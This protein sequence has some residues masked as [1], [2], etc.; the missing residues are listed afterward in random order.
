MRNGLYIVDFHTHIVSQADFESYFAEDCQHHFIKQHGPF[1][2]R[3]LRLSDPHFSD[4]MRHVSFN[5]R[6]EL[7]RSVYNFCG[8]LGLVEAIRIFKTHDFN[9]LLKS[10]DAQGI[11]HAI[12]SS[13]EPLTVTENLIKLVA[14]HKDRFSIFASVHRNQ[15]DPAGYFQQLLESGAVRGLKLHPLV[16]GYNCGELLDKTR[17]VLKVASAHNLP[18]FI[19]TGHIPTGALAGLNGCNDA[20][21]VEPLLAEFP[22]I[23]FVLAHIGWESWRTMLKL[24]RKYPKVYVETSWQPSTIIRRAVDT[25]GSH[26]VIFGSDFPLFKQG[27]ALKQVEQALT[28]YEL[29]AVASANAARLLNLPAKKLSPAA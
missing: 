6:H 24:A 11:D 20:K 25:L 7:A 3:L 9:Y 4:F 8:H 2:E 27:L 14:N 17:D 23:N 16:G 21:A 13:L 12:I 5:F 28:P 10:M 18:V 26:R 19:H 15:E 29:A 1:V 22:E